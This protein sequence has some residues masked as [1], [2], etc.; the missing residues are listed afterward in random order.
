MGRGEAGR[1]GQMEGVEWGGEGSFPSK[2]CWN[3]GARL[4]ET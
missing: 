1:Q 3:L 4:T 2:S